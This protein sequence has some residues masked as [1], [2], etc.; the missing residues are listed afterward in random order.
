MVYSSKKSKI[1][2]DITSLRKKMSIAAAEE[3][4]QIQ[5]QVN[6][7]LKKINSVGKLVGNKILD[8]SRK[9]KIPSTLTATT[10]TT[11]EP[12]RSKQQDKITTTTDGVSISLGGDNLIDLE[13][14]NKSSTLTFNFDNTSQTSETSKNDNLLDYDLVNSESMTSFETPTTNETLIL[15]I[16]SNTSIIKSTNEET[17][18]P[19][20]NR[21]QF[22]T[23]LAK[24]NYIREY[25]ASSKTS[26]LFI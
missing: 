11:V 10:T 19:H 7:T 16:P 23:R 3:L 18:V 13:L 14:E 4:P 8:F 6:S 17:F 2:K 25:T 26:F 21:I 9:M 15:D 22:T 12:D 1:P 5:I 20:L 24:L